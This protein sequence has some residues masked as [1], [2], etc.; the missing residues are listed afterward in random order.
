MTRNLSSTA[1]QVAMVL[2]CAAKRK[3]WLGEEMHGVWSGGCQAKR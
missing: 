2:V 3:Q 1:G